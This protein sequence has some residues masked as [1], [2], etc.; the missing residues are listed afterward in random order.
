MPVHEKSLSTLQAPSTR[1]GEQSRRIFSSRPIHRRSVLIVDDNPEKTLALQSVVE[2]LD[3][4]VVVASSASAA[5]REL[6]QHD[7]ALALLDVHM[8]EMDGFELAR[9]IRSRPAHDHLAIVFISALEHTDERLEDAYNLGAMDFIGLPARRPVLKA[10]LSAILGLQEKAEQEIITEKKEGEAARLRCVQLQEMVAELEAFSYSVSHDLRAPL[11]T[12]RGFA[13]VVLQ[14]YAGALSGPGLLYMNRIRDAAERLERM[15]SD[16]LA[17]SRLPRDKVD[18]S[19]VDLHT[20]L[21]SIIDDGPAF[22]PPD[23]KV[24]V[25]GTLPRVLGHEPS[26]RQ[27]FFNLLAN[28][29]KFMPQGRTPEVIVRAE[30]QDSDTLIW[31]EDN[32]VGLRPEDHERVFRVFERAASAEAF[33]GSGVGLAIVRRSVERMGGSVGVQSELGAGSR[34]WVRLR[35]APP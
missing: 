20:I 22:R 16:I 27:I 23:A 7:F 5:L 34:F 32:G 17:F 11:R 18:L 35:T 19:P 3:C 29:V 6:L 28:S 26:L 12:I 13:S 30:P 8:P 31:I 10:K 25:V 9:L 21:A 15:V 24:A 33:P 4:D 1:G 14:D 2:E